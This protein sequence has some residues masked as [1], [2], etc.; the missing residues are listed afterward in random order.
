MQEFIKG[1][2]SGIALM[3]FLAF[4]WFLF[5]EVTENQG[6][7]DK[8]VIE[9]HTPSGGDNKDLILDMVRATG[10]QTNFLYEEKEMTKHF[11]KYRLTN[12]EK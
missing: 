1:F 12:P 7:K 9:Y 4:V 6:Y 2:F 10:I 3:L 8:L 5:T 11:I